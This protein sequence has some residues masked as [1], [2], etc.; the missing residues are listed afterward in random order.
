MEVFT[1]FLNNTLTILLIISLIIYIIFLITRFLDILFMYD[2]L[3]EIVDL[4]RKEKER[5]EI[6]DNYYKARREY[7]SLVCVKKNKSKKDD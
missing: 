3:K 1:S 7:C 5:Q 2:D 4:H 6:I